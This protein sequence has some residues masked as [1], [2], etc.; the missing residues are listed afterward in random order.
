[1]SWLFDSP[2]NLPGD[3]FIVSQLSLVIGHGSLTRCA[4]FPSRCCVDPPWTEVRA[5]GI[6][7]T[8]G[9]DSHRQPLSEGFPSVTRIFN[10]GWVSG[11]MPRSTTPTI[12]AA[13]RLILTNKSLILINFG[14]DAQTHCMWVIKDDRAIVGA[15][16][17]LREASYG[18]K[19][20]QS[21][22][23][24]VTECYALTR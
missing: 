12:A 9:T 20:A 7:S 2:G 22:P 3:F 17:T 5:N 19:S 16:H 18:C 10:H 24:L 21:L 8:E 4:T 1:M 15:W 6:K 11:A 23:S 14:F 13:Y